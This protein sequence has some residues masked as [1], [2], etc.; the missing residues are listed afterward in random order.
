MSSAHL[1]SVVQAEHC[2][3]RSVECACGTGTGKMFMMQSHV[4]SGFAPNAVEGAELGAVAAATVGHAG[5]SMALGL[6]S[7]WSKKHEQLDSTMSMT[8][9]Y[10]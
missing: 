7:R 10:T 2:R 5:K 3:F 1:Q 9:W 4:G 8:T 6:P